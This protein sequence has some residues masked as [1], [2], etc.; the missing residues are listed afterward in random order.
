M[1]K[2]VLGR[3]LGAF[4][5][6]HSPDV[7]QTPP[8]P[9]AVALDDASSANPHP[10]PLTPSPPDHNS[11]A[12]NTVLRVP[13]EDIRPNPHQPRQEFEQDALFELAQ[14]IRQHGLIQPVTVRSIGEGRFELI[15]GERRLRASRLA[16]HKDIPAYIRDAEDDDMMAMA[17]VE[18]I[19]RADLNP[20]EVAI[21]YQ[22]LIEEFEITQAEAAERVGKSRTAV[23][24]SLRLLQLPAAV[25]SAIRDAT[26]SMGHA[27]ALIN[28]RDEKLQESILKRIIAQDLS[29]REV[30]DIVRGL[31][32]KQPVK[33]RKGSDVSPHHQALVGRMRDVLG[34]K[35]DLKATAEGGQIRI[36]YYSDD[37]LD[38]ILQLIE[39]GG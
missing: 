33:P 36:H 30:E 19:Q 21:A 24:N 39:S 25:Q 10:T 13:I 9:V 34:T 17:L 4:F 18:N 37:D 16:G 32:K 8:S 7:V 23:T 35:V 29:V 1:A 20:I 2:K 28:V 14:S 11:A 3:G 5:P 6:E 12:V 27:R 26:V 22:R 38:R 31:E 15:S